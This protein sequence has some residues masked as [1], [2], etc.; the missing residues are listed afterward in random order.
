LSNITNKEIQE[1]INKITKLQFAEAI[2]AF[3]SMESIRLILI[4]IRIC[5]SKLGNS[6]DVLALSETANIIEKAI[7]E[8]EDSSKG[9]KDSS[10]L[11][12]NLINQLNLE[13]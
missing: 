12:G 7:I 6:P 9:I 11:I 4:N 2:K 1:E 10:K 8:L 13:D 3:N 5:V